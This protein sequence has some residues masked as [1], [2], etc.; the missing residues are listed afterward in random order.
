MDFA[1]AVNEEARDLQAA[2]ADVIQ[3]GRA[4]AWQRSRGR[5]ALCVRAINRALT[6][7][8]VLTAVSAAAPCRRRRTR[9]GPPLT[10]SHHPRSRA[11]QAG[12]SQVVTPLWTGP[13]ASL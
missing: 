8:T 5:E 12:S 13:Q 9:R 6:G 11:D 10:T 7:L 2:G 3:P 4:L 1:T